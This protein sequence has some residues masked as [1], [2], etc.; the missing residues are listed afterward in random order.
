MKRNLSNLKEWHKTKEDLDSEYEDSNDLDS[1][2]EASDDEDCVVYS[3]STNQKKD[4]KYSKNTNK[5]QRRKKL[6]SMLAR[7]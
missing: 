3:A 5:Q 7:I 1:P 2:D 4:L 6:C